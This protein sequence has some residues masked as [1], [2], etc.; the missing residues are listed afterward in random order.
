MTKCRVIVCIL[1]AALLIC[2]RALVVT[3]N[4]RY[5]MFVG[6]CSDPSVPKG[7]CLAKVESRNGW[8]WHFYYALNN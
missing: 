2:G 3:E 8:W 6:M 1:L 5:A 7:P 4:Q